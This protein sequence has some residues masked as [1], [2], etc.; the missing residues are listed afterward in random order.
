M[1]V[2]LYKNIKK[3]NL[4]TDNG[5]KRAEIRPG[6][7]FPCK[8]YWNSMYNLTI[9][10]FFKIRLILAMTFTVLNVFQQARRLQAAGAIGG[11]VIGNV[12]FRAVLLQM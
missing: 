10:L 9:I 11:I 6:E 3:K 4:S 2:F 8:Q 1:A 7:M 12:S 5:A